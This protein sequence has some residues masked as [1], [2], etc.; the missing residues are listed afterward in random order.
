MNTT[1]TQHGSGEAQEALAQLRGPNETI[2]VLRNARATEN[3]GTWLAEQVQRSHGDVD[4][5]VVWDAPG[6]AVLAHVVSR[7]LG[8]R[9]VRAY[10]IEGL[11][12]LADSTDVGRRT[13]ALADHFPT[14][15]SVN[16]LVGVARN[17]G[18]DVVAVAAAVSSAALSS[19]GLPIVVAGSSGS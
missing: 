19:A 16:A 5:V 12:E 14:E 7:E 1:G 17:A 13:L 18:L 3:L 8:A 2:N 9:V 10:E 15:N 11:V 4:D 6:S